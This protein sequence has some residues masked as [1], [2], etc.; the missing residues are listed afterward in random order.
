M[1][2][3]YLDTRKKHDMKMKKLMSIHYPI[4]LIPNNNDNIIVS[5]ETHLPVSNET[6]EDNDKVKKE[7]ENERNE[8]QIFLENQLDINS[9]LED[10]IYKLQM[11]IKKLERNDIYEEDDKEPDKIVIKIDKPVMKN[12]KVSI[13]K[14]NISIP[15][16]KK[17]PAVIKNVKIASKKL[18]K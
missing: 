14:P 4:D 9:K 12:P 8:L 16:P 3:N 17:P 5:N 11:N 1:F 10:T 18:D 13:P 15:K 6:N 7:L 2:K